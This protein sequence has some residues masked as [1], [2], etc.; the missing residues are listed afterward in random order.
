MAVANMS[1]THKIYYKK[2]RFTQRKT[3]VKHPNSVVKNI[4]FLNESSIQSE[5]PESKLV[6]D[7]TLFN[8]DISEEHSDDENDSENNDNEMNKDLKSIEQK[9]KLRKE[10]KS[11]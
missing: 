9:S 7:N 11:I 4:D 2:A 1:G 10:S 8:S 3:I 6:K 5:I